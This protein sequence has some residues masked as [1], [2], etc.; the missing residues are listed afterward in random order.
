MEREGGWRDGKKLGGTERKEH[1]EGGRGE[2]VREE[3]AVC[4]SL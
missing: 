2:K 3:G 1:T 4:I